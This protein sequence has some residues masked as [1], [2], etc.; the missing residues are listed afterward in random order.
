MDYKKKMHDCQYC[1]GKGKI[2]KYEI[3]LDKPSQEPLDAFHLWLKKELQKTMKKC[4]EY[5]K[6]TEINRNVRYSIAWQYSTESRML[7]SVIHKY[8]KF[9][10]KSKRCDV[11]GL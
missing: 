5:Y 11:D 2:P 10:K 3:V 1:K 6:K 9:K 8:Y 4:D 7:M